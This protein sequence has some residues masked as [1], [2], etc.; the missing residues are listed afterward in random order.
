LNERDITILRDRDV[1]VSHCPISN[2]KLASGVSPVPRLLDAGV[3][4]SLGTDGPSSNNASDMFEVMK[5]AALLHKGVWRNPTLLPAEK[6]LG[7]ATI[8]GAKALLWEREIGSIEVGKKADIT[9]L[10]FDKPHL[11]PL[12]NELSHLVYAAKASDVETVI[13]NG[14]IVM[15]N[16]EVKTVN[17][18]RLLEEAEKTK[19]DLLNRLSQNR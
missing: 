4:V 14:D 13:I 8:E 19:E 10:N 15:E 17:V 5:I 7:M 12:Y 6:V 9:I 11:R 3:T 1:K 16:R 18:H 2:L